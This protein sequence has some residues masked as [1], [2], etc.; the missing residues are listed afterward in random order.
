MKVFCFHK[1]EDFTKN[2]NQVFSITYEIISSNN[3]KH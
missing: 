2:E 1:F 3:A